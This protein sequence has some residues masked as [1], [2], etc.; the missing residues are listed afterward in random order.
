VATDRQSTASTGQPAGPYRPP[1]KRTAAQRLA[2][3]PV[4]GFIPWIAFW[5]VGG[6]STWETSTLAALLAAI[7][8]TMLSIGYRPLAAWTT[9]RLVERRARPRPEPSRPKL[10]DIATVVFFALLSL[11]ALV[12]T[13]HNV[14][15][16]DKYSQAISSG[17]LGI[18]AL[19]SL[20]V[21]HPF[22]IDYAKQ[23]A[24]PA[25]WPTL[26][27]KRINR[28]LSSVWAAVFLICALLGVTAQQS[29]AK[30]LRDWLNWYIPIVLIFLAFRFTKRYPEQVR[31]QQGRAATTWA[32][33][34][35]AT[36]AAHAA[37]LVRHRFLAWVRPRA[38]PGR[39]RRW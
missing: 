8:V 34:P 38:R 23:K 21:R 31:A 4:V 25:V 29:V 22:T 35:A 10:L 30:G 14:S 16:L 5:V 18:I 37:N 11:A 28:V 26:V 20:V 24:P 33:R 1:D 2:G 7:L 19:G 17:A 32:S 3:H 36:L 15:N 12:T 27:F 9:A 13:R 6:L 39:P